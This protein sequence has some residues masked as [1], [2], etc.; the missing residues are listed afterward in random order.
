MGRRFLPYWLLGGVLFWLLRASIRLSLGFVLLL[1]LLRGVVVCLGCIVGI[2]L[3]QVHV[4]VDTRLNW[5]SLLLH[6]SLLWLLPLDHDRSIAMGAAYRDRRERL[7]DHDL[8]SS[9]SYRMHV[10][11]TQFLIGWRTAGVYAWAHIVTCL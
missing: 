3:S 4:H 1:L 6:N 11:L 9:G 7:V 8:R 10:M 5:S 2:H